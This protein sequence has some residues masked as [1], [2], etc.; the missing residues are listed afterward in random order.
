MSNDVSKLCADFLRASYKSIGAS[1]AREMVAAFFGYKSH[2]ALLSETLYVLENLE[3]SYIL[4]PAIGLMEQRRLRLTDLPADLPASKQIAQELADFLKEQELFTGDVWLVEDLGDYLIEEYLLENFAL[5][6]AVASEI[7][8]T[9]AIFDDIYYDSAELTESAHDVTAV[10]KGLYSGD[11]EDDKPFCGNEIDVVVT[12]KFER[13]AAKIAFLEPEIEAGGSV[14]DD[15]RDYDYDGDEDEPA[16]PE[17]K[18]S[19]TIKYGPITVKQNGK[20]VQELVATPAVA[21]DHAGWRPYSLQNVTISAGV[22]R[23]KQ[24]DQRF[25]TA[26]TCV[27]RFAEYGHEFKH[28]AP[29]DLPS[30]IS[31]GSAEVTSYSIPMN[32]KEFKDIILEIEFTLGAGPEVSIRLPV[33]IP[34]LAKN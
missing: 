32:F 22:I 15:W 28:N 5:D 33:R 9:N 20:V 31:N 29:I 7:A 10:V 26:M 2:A 13:V 34:V 17:P 3:D 12:V 11:L 8:S 24:I 27:T 21:A 6:D 19:A 4:I 23:F 1:H 18:K 25:Y 16:G 30:G 14:R